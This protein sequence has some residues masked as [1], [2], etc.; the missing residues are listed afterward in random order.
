[1]VHDIIVRKDA[2]FK[3]VADLRKKKFGT[4]STGPD[5]SV[6]RERP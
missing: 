4:F 5:R 3:T 6:P 2:P 1:M